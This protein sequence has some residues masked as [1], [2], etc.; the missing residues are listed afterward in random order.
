MHDGSLPKEYP[1][2]IAYT[3]RLST[4]AEDG[5]R[6]LALYSAWPLFNH[7]REDSRLIHHRHCPTDPAE[8][9][10]AVSLEASEHDGGAA[11]HSR[12]AHLFPSEAVSHYGAVAKW[13]GPIACLHAFSSS[14]FAHISATSAACGASAYALLYGPRTSSAGSRLLC[15]SGAGRQRENQTQSPNYPHL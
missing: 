14:V 15:I 1:E 10:M 12:Q 2:F 6:K 5:L 9:L 8:S 3:R 11:G 4:F 13:A 7:N